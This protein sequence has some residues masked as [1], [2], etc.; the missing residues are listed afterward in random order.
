MAI[1][2]TI[3]LDEADPRTRRILDL[4]APAQPAEP[5]PSIPKRA[6]AVMADGEPRTSREIRAAVKGDGGPSFHPQA[7]TNALQNLKLQGRVRLDG[8]QWRIVR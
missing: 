4:L 5:A 7:L 8:R 6:L 1:S 3:T 2:V